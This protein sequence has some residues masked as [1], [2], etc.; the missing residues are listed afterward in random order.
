MHVFQLSDLCFVWDI[1]ARGQTIASVSEVGRIRVVAI[2]HL[3]MFLHG[4]RIA[5]QIIDV[6]YSRVFISFWTLKRMKVVSLSNREPFLFNQ[7]FLIEN[8]KKSFRSKLNFKKTHLNQSKNIVWRFLFEKNSAR[9]TWHDKFNATWKFSRKSKKKSVKKS[10]FV[11]CWVNHYHILS[12]WN[13]SN[14]RAH[15]C[16]WYKLWRISADAPSWRNIV[17]SLGCTCEYH[18]TRWWR[19]GK[20]IQWPFYQL[21]PQTAD[22]KPLWSRPNDV[23][24]LWSSSW[25][26]AHIRSSRKSHLAQNSIQSS[27][28]HFYRSAECDTDNPVEWTAVDQLA[29]TDITI[30][31]PCPIHLHLV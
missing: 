5:K 7:K 6:A 4:I 29:K 23:G 10:W 12:V 30:Q 8:K 14:T 18:L 11:N 9:L 17:W 3:T 31:F 26:D 21:P 2:T 16:F 1:N 19:S 25:L 13:S 27:N 24:T 15:S 22:R 20:C 28:C